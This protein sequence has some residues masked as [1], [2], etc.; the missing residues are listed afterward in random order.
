V[1]RSVK[2]CC[3]ALSI[4]SDFW[5]N[6][7]EHMLNSASLRPHTR[8]KSGIVHHRERTDETVAWIVACMADAHAALSIPHWRTVMEDEFQALLRNNT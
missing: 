7:L 2:I 1:R 6:W 8:S 3:L 5:F 4:S